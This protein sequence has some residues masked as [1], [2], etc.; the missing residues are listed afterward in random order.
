MV[1][2]EGAPHYVHE[3]ALWIC[4]VGARYIFRLNLGDTIVFV[5]VGEVER[6]E[7]TASDLHDDVGISKGCIVFHSI[8]SK[9]HRLGFHLNESPIDVVGVDSYA[10]WEYALDRRVLAV[11]LG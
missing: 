9:F 6:G 11:D 8:N 5:E 2:Q 1:G 10:C 4:G 3:D 7:L